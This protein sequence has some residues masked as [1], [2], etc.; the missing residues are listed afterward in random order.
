VCDIEKGDISPTFLFI[1]AALDFNIVLEISKN[2][3]PRILAMSRLEV[4]AIPVQRIPC[5]RQ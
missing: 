2:G 1:S 3:F 5:L 4:V